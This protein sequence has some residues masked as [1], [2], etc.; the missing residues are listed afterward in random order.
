M[1]GKNTF[2]RTVKNIMNLQ[3]NGIYFSLNTTLHSFNY[4]DIEKILDLGFR[5]LEAHNI[6][7]NIIF[8]LGRGSENNELCLSREKIF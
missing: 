6:N 3:K 1:R 4:L 8:P 5:K 7:I 2:D